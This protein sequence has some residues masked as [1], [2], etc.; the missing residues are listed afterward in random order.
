M[1]RSEAFPGR[2]MT[3]DMVT[4]PMV[5]H[6]AKVETENVGME[7]DPENKPVISF[8]EQGPNI[9]PLACNGTNWDVIEAAYGL[10]SDDWIGKAVELYHDPTVKFGKQRVG[11]IRV[12]IP[13]SLPSKSMTAGA[14]LTYAQYLAAAKAA[15]M[16]EAEF[17]AEIQRRGA[18]TMGD[19][20][21]LAPDVIA[22]FRAK[23]AQD[24]AAEQAATDDTIPF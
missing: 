9:K 7:D 13:E 14:G 5:L 10:D 19:A 8:Q 17:K 4:T 11:G 3:K 16:E 21:R 24:T 23:Q 22:A 18:A 15:G 1:K 2:Y 12:R 6:I 20:K